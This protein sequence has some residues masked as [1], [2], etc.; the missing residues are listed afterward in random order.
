MKSNA[1]IS[2]GGGPC[3]LLSVEEAASE[4]D[5]EDDSLLLELLS[6]DEI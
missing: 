2:F 1:S 4:D 5:S 6:L 3:R